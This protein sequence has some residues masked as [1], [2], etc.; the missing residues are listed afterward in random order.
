MPDKPINFGARFEYLSAIE[1]HWPEVLKSLRDSTFPVYRT[2]W[3]RN[4]KSLALQ[5][6][7]RLSKASR[8]ARPAAFRR[9]ER[10]VR[11]WATAYGFRNTWILDAAVRSMYSWAFERGIS[12]WT[13][14]PEE[15]DTPMF[16]PKFGYWIPLFQKWPEF[17]QSADAIYRR[18]Q[19]NYRTEIRKLWGEGQPKLSQHAAWTVLWQRGKSPEAIRIY[20]LKTTGKNVS[21]ANIQL[22]VHAFA[23]SA[24]LTL[25]A[26]KAGPAARI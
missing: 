15:L 17:K 25:R 10:A 12:K 13:Y 6:L 11:R 1:A 7:A 19:A 23:R 4:P 16:E 5:T 8:N 3:E 20:H 21:V 26:A 14:F 22:R 2:C 9:V 18:E 24:G